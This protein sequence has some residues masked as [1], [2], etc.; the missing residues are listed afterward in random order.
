MDL[1]EYSKR[2]AGTRQY[3]SIGDNLN[4][5]VRGLAGEVGEINEKLKKIERDDGI[6]PLTSCKQ[7]T[8]KHKEALLKEL[9]DVLWYVNALTLELGYTLEGVA[10]LNIE[11]LESRQARNKI[12]GSGDDR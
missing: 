8:P 3:P 11:K 12:K 2:A 1:K 10:T 4:Y 7:L 5:P 9:G 6:S